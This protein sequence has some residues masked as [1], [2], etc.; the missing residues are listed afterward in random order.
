MHGSKGKYLFVTWKA[1]LSVAT[2]APSKLR[3]PVTGEQR[4]ESRMHGCVVKALQTFQQV[5]EV[6]QVAR[7]TGACFNILAGNA[8]NMPCFQ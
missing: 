6:L 7:G 8:H 5:I 3:I 1:A 2:S 4:H